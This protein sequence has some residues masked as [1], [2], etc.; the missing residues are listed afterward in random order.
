LVVEGQ[1]GVGQERPDQL[2]VITDPL[3]PC[4]AASATSMTVSP[5]KLANSTR[6][7]YQQID[8]WHSHLVRHED[9][10]GLPV[11]NP[12]CA[13]TVTGHGRLGFIQCNSLSFI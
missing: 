9:S 11:L 7:G 12:A 8:R 5:A 2:L 4:S 10:D 1:A 13:R 3:I 6:T